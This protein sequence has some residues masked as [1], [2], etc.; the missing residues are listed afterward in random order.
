MSTS[1]RSSL[2]SL[3]ILEDHQRRISNIGCLMHLIKGSIGPGL[4][5]LP[6]GVRHAG[7]IAGPIYMVLIALINMHCMQ[8]LVKSSRYLCNYQPWTTVTLDIIVYYMVPFK[9]YNPCI[10]S[11]IFVNACLVLTQFGICC[12]FVL[13]VGQNIRQVFAVYWE[14][15]PGNRVFMALLIIPVILLTFIENLLCL[16]GFQ[17]LRMPQFISVGMILRYLTP[18]LPPVTSRPFI[19]EI[20]DFPLFVGGVI[21]AFE[22]IGV[23]LPLENA[24]RTPEY[25]P[26]IIYIGMT[27]ISILYIVFGFIGYLKFGSKACGSITLNLPITPFYETARVLYSFALFVTYPLQ[28]YVIMEIIRA[29]ID[30]D[31]KLKTKYLQ[32]TIKALIATFSCVCAIAVPSLG[33]YIS[34]VGTTVTT[35]LAII[36]PAVIETLT[37]HE[38]AGTTYQ[39]IGD[40]TA[41]N[42][43]SSD[44]ENERNE[45]NEEALHTKSCGHWNYAKTHSS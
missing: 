40:V 32:W 29:S 14:N 28:F 8:I 35:T 6:W 25:F 9:D 26:K 19:A 21:Y 22:G 20:T 13:F 18:N 11:R 12:V 27:M 36:L 43:S 37:F 31:S 5:M 39:P 41:G 4:L 33:N 45:K 24:M 34:L 3:F 17:Q 1:S 38:K 23:I 30:P 2:S 15:I 42:A 16:L 7:I 44:E 10:K